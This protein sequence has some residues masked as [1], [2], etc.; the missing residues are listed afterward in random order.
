VSYELTGV[1]LKLEQTSQQ[2]TVPKVSPAVIEIDPPLKSPLLLPMPSLKEPNVDRM[3]HK[4]S[5]IVR[6]D[7]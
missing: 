7:C 4:V 1:M 3:G 6:L 5:K 2:L